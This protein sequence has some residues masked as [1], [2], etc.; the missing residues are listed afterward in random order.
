ML[1]ADVPV[2]VA[3]VVA[4]VKVVDEEPLP[5]PLVADAAEAVVVTEAVVA[6]V[7][8]PLA[9]DE[10]LVGL[11]VELGVEAVLVEV[12]TASGEDEDSLELLLPTLLLPPALL[13]L[14]PAVT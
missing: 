4:L 6:S 11:R 7:E 13:P 12:L 9:P 10:P 8:A 3:L 5:P 1:P 2:A 14:L